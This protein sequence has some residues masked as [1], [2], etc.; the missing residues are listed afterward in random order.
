MGNRVAY[1]ADPERGRLPER[2]MPS[3]AQNVDKRSLSYWGI[4]GNRW[5]KIEHQEQV[6]FLDI[7]V[8]AKVMVRVSEDLKQGPGITY[9]WWKV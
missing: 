5:S 8:S 1:P 6:P 4:P 7:G 2:M 9:T 3:W